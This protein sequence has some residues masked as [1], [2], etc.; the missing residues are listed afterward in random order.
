[1][2]HAE[3]EYLYAAPLSQ[4]DQL[5]KLFSENGNAL[6]LGQIMRTTLAAEYRARLSE[7]RGDGYIITCQI[8]KPASANLYTLTPPVKFE[9]GQGVM[10]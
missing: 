8:R 2:P 3:E 9:D 4:R 1:M 7:M 10:L 5:L 6:T